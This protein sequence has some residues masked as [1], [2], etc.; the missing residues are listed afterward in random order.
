[1]KRTAHAKFFLCA[2]ILMIFLPFFYTF[3][4][5][6]YYNG[7]LA[8]FYAAAGFSIVILCAGLLMCNRMVVKLTY[9]DAAFMAF[10]LFALANYL[11]RD[12]HF[13]NDNVFILLL[14]IAIY[15]ALRF[16]FFKIPTTNFQL[17]PHLIFLSGIACLLWGYLQVAKVIPSPNPVFRATGPFLHPNTFCAF[18]SVC[19]PAGV[20]LLFQP[21]PRYL[22][23]PAAFFCLGVLHLCLLLSSRAAL[24]ATVVATIAMVLMWSG[25][26]R[27]IAVIASA[28]LLFV[29]VAG[30]LLVKQNSSFGRMLIW[31]VSSDIVL[32]HPV[33]GV[34]F[35]NF[36]KAYNNVQ[37]DYFSVDRLDSEVLVATENYSSFN[38]FYSIL[39]EEGVVGLLLFIAA[40]YFLFVH[41]LKSISQMKQ[42]NAARAIAQV[43]VVSILVTGL[44][45]NPLT[46]P[47][48]L[49]FFIVVAAATTASSP[50]TILSFR[51]T[52]VYLIIVTFLLVC[53]GFL[54]LHRA[55]HFKT[56]NKMKREVLYDSEMTAQYDA[57]YTYFASNGFYLSDYAAIQVEAGQKEKAIITL[58][59]AITFLPSPEVYTQLG[60]LYSSL[61]EKKAEAMFIKASQIVPSKFRYRY[62]LLTFYKEHGEYTKARKIADQIVAMPVKIPSAEIEKVKQEAIQY[63][64]PDY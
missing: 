3:C 46:D 5:D 49:A 27:K 32:E 2:P 54:A 4:N 16:A 17:L 50:S 60:M 12:L 43:S 64:R 38:E 34:G 25:K 47:A 42:S 22:K 18:L 21:K 56:W 37:A 7:N 40:L 45:N 11:V 26:R 35:G 15:T 52:S 1:M 57:L 63:L 51:I 8:A 55:F 44:F 6:L 61:D 59:R 23:I 20:W 39:I 29:V 41:K 30:S 36:K 58:E 24:I 28:L 53:T 19:F 31:K 48:L 10:L 9:F 14:S 62:Y 13:F 33:A